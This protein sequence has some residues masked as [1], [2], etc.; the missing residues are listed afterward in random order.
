[1]SEGTAFFVVP[2]PL[3]GLLA[4]LVAGLISYLLGYGFAVPAMTC[5]ALGAVIPYIIVL[6]QLRW[7]ARAAFM[8][9]PVILA[10]IIIVSITFGYAMPALVDAIL[11][12]GRYADANLDSLVELDVNPIIVRAMGAGAVAASGLITLLRTAPTIVS[13]LTQGF[14]QMG[15]KSK[16]YRFYHLFG[17]WV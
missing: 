1:M 17:F 12:V 11:A 4:A 16:T 10:G 14:K 3:L 15:Q 7:G 8:V 5:V 13:A 2:F 9:L 6:Q